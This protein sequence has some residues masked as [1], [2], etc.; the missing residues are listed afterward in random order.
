MVVGVFCVLS[1]GI[2]YLPEVWE[3][4]NLKTANSAKV[5]PMK[6]VK[7]LADVE[8]IDIYNLPRIY[9]NIREIDQAIGGLYFGQLI[10]LTGSRGEGRVLS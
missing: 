7:E 4:D 6:N 1:N 8:S 3:R 9:T 5:P 2:R 10:L